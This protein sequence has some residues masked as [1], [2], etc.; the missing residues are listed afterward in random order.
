M[1]KDQR[2][3]F[4]AIVAGLLA[5]LPLYACAQA[6]DSTIIGM[7]DAARRGNSAQLSAMLPNA[8]GHTLEPWAAYWELKARLESASSSEVDAFLQ[9]YKGSYQEDRLR[10]DWLLV[11]GKRGDYSSFMRYYPEFRMRDD[12]DVACYALQAQ[13]ALGQQPADAADTLRDQWYSQRDA[14]A[15]CAG[16]AGA[17]LNKGAIKEEDVW[18]KARLNADHPR[19]SAAATTAV[20]VLDGGAAAQA[21]QAMANPSDFL[22]AA[23]G[24]DERTRELAVLALARMAGTNPGEAALTMRSGWDERLS[25][26]Q[27]DWIWGEIGKQASLNLDGRTL[28]YYQNVHHMKNLD[29]VQLAWWVRAALRTGEWKPIVPAIDAMSASERDDATWVYWKA[30]ALEQTGHKHQAEAL[31]EKIKG[32]KG[33]YEQLATEALGESIVPPAA[34]SP[35]TAQERAQTRANP[36]LQRAV[37][38]YN[39]GL[40]S[41]ATREW[42]YTTNLHE[43]GGMD[44]R[45]LLAA[46]E[47]ACQMQWWDRCINTSERTRTTVDMASR[48]PQPYRELVERSATASGLDPAL[49]MGLIR[50]ESRFQPNARSGAGASGLMQVMPATARITARKEGIGYSDGMINNTETNVRLGTAYLRQMMD[51]FNGSL[52]MAVAGYNAGPGRPKNWRGYKNIEGAAWAESI[53][54]AETRDYVKKVTANAVNYGLILYPGKTQSLRQRLG[55]ITPEY[56]Y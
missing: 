39:I 18:R 1:Q 19:R 47:W 10:N 2:F 45:G 48:F 21:S 26:S 22:A 12:K 16:A 52:P 11:L 15:S 31:Y 27:R 5:V 20:A 8:Q 30:R 23:N 36:G 46:A 38:A 51:S 43:R 49:A 7:S 3:Q 42:N 37:Y 40:R 56:N 4:K 6:S 28:E 35:V 53:P 17:L 9:R 29:D 14:G 55:T 44:D 32:T 50:Q 13:V 25:K 54:F 24:S 41:E 34:P 33:F